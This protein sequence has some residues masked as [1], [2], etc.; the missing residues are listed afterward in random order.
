MIIDSLFAASAR[1][2][3]PLGNPELAA[4]IRGAIDGL[5][6]RPVIFGAGCGCAGAFS[7]IS[8]RDFEEALVFHV[9]ER[10]RAIRPNTDDTLP[11]PSRLDGLDALL[12]WALALETTGMPGECRTVVEE[13]DKSLV[14]FARQCARHGFKAEDV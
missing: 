14:S 1:R 9:S 3:A 5:R 6:R 4:K 11:D 10:W 7:A 13:I 12:D 2:D 8:I